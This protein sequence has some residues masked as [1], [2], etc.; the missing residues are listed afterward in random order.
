[1][2]GDEKDEVYMKRRRGSSEENNDERIC[3]RK[4][5]K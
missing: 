2:Q 3:A 1:M 5:E 4:T